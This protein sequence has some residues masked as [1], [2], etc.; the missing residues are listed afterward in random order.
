MSFGAHLFGFNSRSRLPE[1]LLFVNDYSKQTKDSVFE[2]RLIGE[3]ALCDNFLE[4]RELFFTST[5]T[6]INQ[7]V[8]QS[9]QQVRATGNL[10]EKLQYVIRK[11]VAGKL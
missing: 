4:M 5:Q 11:R 3:C 9:L 2:S 8:L 6:K 1:H 10:N 7:F